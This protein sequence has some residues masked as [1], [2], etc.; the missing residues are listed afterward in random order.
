VSC[1]IVVFAK[2]PWPGRVKTRLAPALGAEGAARLA[3]RFLAHTLAQAQA[4]ALGPVVLCVAGGARHPGVRQLARSAGVAL[5]A[6]GRGGL[7]RRMAQALDRMRAVS[8]HALLVGTDVPALDAATL[9]R[10][11]AALSRVGAVF[12]PTADGGYALVGL[13]QAVPGLFDGMRWSHAGVM[14]ATRERLAAAGC[15][16]R[17]LP[18]MHDVDRPDDLRWVPPGWR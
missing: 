5:W 15:R 3:E 9:R 1:G 6:Q 7:G 18:P 2:A 16:W 12:G 17:E 8:P 10:A 13:A 4:A 11:A 14:Q